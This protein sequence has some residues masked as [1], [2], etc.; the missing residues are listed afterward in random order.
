MLP[1]LAPIEPLLHGLFAPCV[2]LSAAVARDARPAGASWARIFASGGRAPSAIGRRLPA[3]TSGRTSVCVAAPI[4]AGEV[5]KMA[6]S[7]H[8][9]ARWARQTQ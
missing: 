5:L 4:P 7:S 2:L 1:P 3:P 8:L 6:C 9:R